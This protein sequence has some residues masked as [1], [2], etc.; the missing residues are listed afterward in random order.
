MLATSLPLV[1]S[2][3][4]A[5][6][7]SPEEGNHFLVFLGLAVKRRNAFLAKWWM[8]FLSGLGAMTLAVGGFMAGYCLL[9]KRMPFDMAFCLAVIFIMWNGSFGLYVIHMIL[10]LWKPRSLSICA[11]AAESVVS[12]LMLTGLGDGL[13]QFLPC[14]YAGRWEGH[15]FRYYLEGKLPLEESVLKASFGVNAVILAGITGAAMTG[16]YYYE[17]RRVND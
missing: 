4:C 6:A 5:Q 13:W 16:F 2:V 11:G 12:A 1:I 9:L 17:G 10:N 8:V 15:F 3:V 14:A 7:V